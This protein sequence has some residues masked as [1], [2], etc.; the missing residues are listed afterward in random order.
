MT[1]FDSLVDNALRQQPQFSSLRIVVEKELLHHDILR[2]M[3][4]AGLLQQLTFIGGT[5]LRACYGSQRLSEDL[6]FSGGTN[7]TKEQLVGMADH[8][9]ETL[10]DKYS[11]QVEVSEPT[12]ESG[13]V[14]TWKLKIQTRSGRPD[15][16]AQKI[17]IDVCAVP[18]YDP[19]PRM[20]L[21]PYGVDMGTMGLILNAESREE[22]FCDKLVAFALRPNR[23]KY[24]DLWDIVWLHQAGIKPALDFLAKKLTDHQCLPETFTASFTE[25]VLLLENDP[26][27]EAGFYKEMQ[28]FL[29]LAQLQTVEQ[30]GFWKYL[31]LLLRDLKQQV[32]TT[33]N[34]YS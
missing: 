7:F 28:R 18:S 27:I 3:S 10:Q 9:R 20:L 14:D 12:R 11:L 8:L 15:L 1:L 17:N 31:N 16:P 25:R 5:C 23:L 24:R 6:D 26:Q 32:E 19:Q 29:A 33:I 2:A 30:P 13:N 21:N 34:D 4:E 22:I